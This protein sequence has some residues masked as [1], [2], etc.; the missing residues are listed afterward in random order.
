[1]INQNYDELTHILIGSVLEDYF[2][3]IDKSLQHSEVLVKDIDSLLNNIFKNI[4]SVDFD[5]K[6]SNIVIEFKS[7]DQDQHS[8]QVIKNVKD[9]L[10]ILDL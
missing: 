8:D 9:N 7:M 5:N 2:K 6:S 1:M 3:N 10:I 4:I